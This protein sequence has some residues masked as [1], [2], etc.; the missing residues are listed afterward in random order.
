MED[1]LF[2]NQKRVKRQNEKE[3]TVVIGNPPYNQ[4]QKSFEDYN[5]NKQYPRIKDRIKSEYGLDDNGNNIYKK[6]GVKKQDVTQD[7][8][9]YFLRW[10]TDRIKKKGIVSFIINRSFLD[11]SSGVGVRYRL[12]REFDH[13]Y[14]IDLEGDIRNGD[15]QKSNV[16]DIMTGVA[17]VFLVKSSESKK[18]K[19]KIKYLNLSEII[20][21]HE[22]TYKLKELHDK[23]IGIFLK[24]NSFKPIPPNKKYQWIK[25]EVGNEY[26]KLDD[27]FSKTFPGISTQRDNDVYDR[28]RDNLTKKIKDFIN[29]FKKYPNKKPGDYKIKLSEDLKKKI[30]KG[31]H[32]GLIFNKNKIEKVA[33][34]KNDIRF[35]Y[36]EKILSDRLTQSHF[37]LW[38]NNLEKKELSLLY[39]ISKKNDLQV[40]VSYN[41]VDRHY[42][43]EVR[44][45]PLKFFKKESVDFFKRKLKTD[46]ISKAYV[47]CYIVGLF[48]SDRYKK[49]VK[50]NNCEKKNLPIPIWDFEKYKK[51]GRKIIQS[52]EEESH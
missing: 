31:Q 42:L 29:E 26:K 45:L 35:F 43:H 44:I 39:T 34:K 50:E 3:I 40:D 17:I 15:P 12:E 51:A 22:K 21:G 5:Q 27:I 8:Y 1:S 10:A 13:I 47:F 11:A 46:K 7:R 2:E 32:K 4:G 36:A 20:G 14:I 33:Y 18:E 6:F 25:Q 19:A 30:I 28:D 41:P 37:E 52:I 16:F 49:F 24:E 9:I 48:H 23:D 38:G